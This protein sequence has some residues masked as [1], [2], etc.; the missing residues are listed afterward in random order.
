MP[1]WQ[2]V[3]ASVAGASHRRRGVECQ[4][5]HAV[6]R[7]DTGLVIAVADGAGSAPRAA[8]GAQLAVTAAAY[9]SRRGISD[10]VAILSR[11]RTC[12]RTWAGSVASLRE[13]AT[14]LSVVVLTPRTVKVAQIGDGA[15][16]LMRDNGFELLRAVEAGEY[17]NETVFLTSTGWRAHMRRDSRPIDGVTGVAVFSDGLQLVAL[18]LAASQAHPGFFNPLFDFAAA[19]DATDDE[20]AAFLASERVRARTD[21]D[22]TLVLAAAA[23]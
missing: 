16:V 10:P 18:D 19:P 8:E 14:T 13:L 9:W 5:A 4:D 1:A 15:V 2:V 20:L 23:S 6:V 21:D 12:L 7:T 17:L 3:G 22:S 11:A